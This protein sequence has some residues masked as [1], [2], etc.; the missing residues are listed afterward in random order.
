METKMNNKTNELLEELKT[1]S[2]QHSEIE[3]VLVFGSVAR[4]QARKESDLDLCILLKKEHTKDSIS[5]TLL[6]LEKKYNKNINIVFT[7]SS[8]KDLDRQFI[9]TIL[10]E[11]ITIY[12]KTPDASIQQLELEPYEIIRFDLSNLDQSKKMK[13][14]RLLYGVKTK[15]EYKGKTYT[16]EQKGLVEQLG[17]LRVGIASVLIPEKK[18]WELEEV[19]RKHQVSLRKITIWLSNP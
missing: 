14:K 8:F 5:N 2:I 13:M 17:G 12:G 3:S 9:E 7:D 4:G 10:R 1:I 6:D 18:S 16:N 11:G 15:K 19:L